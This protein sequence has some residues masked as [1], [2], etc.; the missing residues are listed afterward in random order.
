[1]SLWHTTVLLCHCNNP[2]VVSN[3]SLKKKKGYVFI[4]HVVTIIGVD[5]CLLKLS[6]KGELLVVVGRDVSNNMY[7]IAFVVVKAE[8]KDF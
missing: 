4:K 8:T 5:R 2:L 1:M 7:L 6:F 3:V